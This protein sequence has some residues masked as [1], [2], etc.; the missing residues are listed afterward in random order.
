M[1]QK[2]VSGPCISVLHTPD[3]YTDRKYEKYACNRLA[4]RYG[5]VYGDKGLFRSR[6]DEVKLCFPGEESREERLARQH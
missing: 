4:C 6:R 3:I 5:R 2:M 1:I